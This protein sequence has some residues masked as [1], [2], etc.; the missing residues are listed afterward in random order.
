MSHACNITIYN[1]DPSQTLSLQ[2]ISNVSGSFSPALTAGST[3]VIAG[4]S[5]RFTLTGGDI[6][7]AAAT[8]VWAI[9]TGDAAAS[10]TMVFENDIAG[11][12]NTATL[13]VSGSPLAMLTYGVS[14]FYAAEGE[15]TTLARDYINPSGSITNVSPVNINYYIVN[16]AYASLPSNILPGITNVVMLMLENRG[17]DHLLGQIYTENNPPNRYF[18]TTNPPPFNGIGANPSFS[19]VNAATGETVT[20]FPVDNNVFDTPDP[21]PGE[22]YGNTNQQLFNNADQQPSQGPPNM[23]GFLNNYVAQPGT[24]SNSNQIMQYYTPA[25][26]PVISGLATQ[27]AVSDAWFCSVPSQTFTNR[28]FSVAGTAS[29]VVD[30]SSLGLT[31]RFKMNTIFNV[32]SNCSFG[33]NANWSLYYQDHAF[34]TCA[35]PFLFEQLGA[36]VTD[37]QVQPISQFFNDLTNDTLPQFCYVEPAW[38]YTMFEVEFL[39]G[40]DYHPPA[41][42]CPGE[43]ML[44]QIYTALTQYTKW[45]STLFIVT[46]DEH[47]GNFDHVQPPAT[48]SPDD[49]RI[50]PGFFDFT[51]LGIRVPTLLISPMIENGM[52]FRAPGDIPF[53][54]TSFLATILGW[55]NIDISGGVLGARAAQAPNFS[56][57]LS[58]RPV[59]T[60]IPN[61][62]P[63]AGC[64]GFKDDD[65]K[66]N[67]FQRWLFPA[68][69]YS[70]VGGEA[71]SDEHKR[72][73]REL[74]S[75]DTLFQLRD[76]VE[77]ERKRL[78]SI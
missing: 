71:G 69:A 43:S 45:N 21:D 5:L 7:A 23:G 65:N 62:S 35:T 78:A 51:R 68:L 27:Y 61:L 28:A 6:E 34:D 39:K 41:N 3:T 47:G 44:L 20:I 63:A 49:M 17:F 24:G 38:N 2:S 22:G 70:I 31:S 9:G 25:Q 10:C 13:Q 48:V 40:N 18:P 19:N 54:H 58:A 75:L 42:L 57:V 55:M 32:M 11:A 66:L 64:A 1:N 74:E 72:V 76:Y 53:D 73:L 33:G 46:F 15:G 50:G 26:L 16:N 4:E 67:G 52:V 59:N 60:T 12:E 77:G 29:G 14:Y 30:N 37:E 56:G 36:L 8:L